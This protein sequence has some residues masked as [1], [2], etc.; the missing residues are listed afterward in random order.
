MAPLLL[1]LAAPALPMPVQILDVLIAL[2]DE[3]LLRNPGTLSAPA[4]HDDFA[5]FVSRYF[6]QPALQ[7]IV[8]QVQCGIDMPRRI[9]IVRADIDNDRGVG[10]FQS[11]GKLGG[12]DGLN[13]ESLCMATDNER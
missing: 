9:F 13:R 12:S 7:F 10:L 3:N 11:L 4:V 1:R 8:R 2:F 6:A 5:G